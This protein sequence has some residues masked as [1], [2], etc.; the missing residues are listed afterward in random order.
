MIDAHCIAVFRNW[1]LRVSCNL[2]GACARTLATVSEATWSSRSRSRSKIALI[3][4]AP[5]HRP[6]GPVDEK[7]GDHGELADLFELDTVDFLA[8]PGQF[9][10]RLRASVE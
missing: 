6:V 7:A 4:D 8:V 10:R 3:P 1:R 9:I 5:R 2:V